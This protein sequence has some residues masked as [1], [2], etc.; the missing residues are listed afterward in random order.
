MKKLL[1]V[2]LLFA[3]FVSGCAGVDSE[4]SIIIYKVTCWNYGQVVFEDFVYKDF[5][6]T[7]RYANDEQIS[8]DLDDCV[9]I[10]VT[11]EYK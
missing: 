9:Y 10:D 3:I 6:A 7:Y 11:N 1:V 4:K 2:L 8:I 5:W